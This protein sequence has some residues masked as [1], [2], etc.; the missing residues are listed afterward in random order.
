[1]NELLSSCLAEIDRRRERAEA[2]AEKTRLRLMETYPA[3]ASLEKEMNATGV[4]ILAVFR[5]G[6][7]VT[8]A[9]E[10]LRRENLDVQQKRL[11]YL[12]S[13]GEDPACLE[14]H[15]TCSLC[16]DTGFVGGERCKCLQA[17]MASKACD[18]LNDSSPLSLSSFETFDLSYFEGEDRETMENIFYFVRNYAETFS[19]KSDNLLFYGGTGLGK[20]HLSLAV[21]G[22]VLK[23]G[24]DVV[25]GQAQTL[26][27]RV[28]DERFSRD[29]VGSP[30]EESLLSCD[31]LILD[32]L[33]AELNTQMSQAVLYNI[34]NTRLLRKKPMIVSTNIPLNRLDGTYHERI[35][36][37]LSFEFEP[38]PFVG[39]DVRQKRKH[40]KGY[41]E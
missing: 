37:R 27:T 5:R 15:Y 3:F 17:L 14:P 25:Y 7:N 6:E 10:K 32:D 19:E 9:L 35:T 24:Y 29:S 2:E 34:L 4:E 41:D 30:T 20:T 36:S 22:V 1:M 40:R 12:R 13:V 23:K 21:A 11:E 16:R 33:G 26:L 31:L 8:E 38:V 39:S 28:T 18:L